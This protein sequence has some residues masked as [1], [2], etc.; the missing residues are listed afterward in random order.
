MLFWSDSDGR[1]ART[2]SISANG[3][4]RR[5]AAWQARRAH[6]SEGAAPAPSS[7][8]ATAATRM[9]TSTSQ[10]A[11]APGA[12]SWIIAAGHGALPGLSHVT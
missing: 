8:A 6:A 11:C 4:Q 12:G 1:S 7:P 10:A 3:A 5:I 2:S 9:H